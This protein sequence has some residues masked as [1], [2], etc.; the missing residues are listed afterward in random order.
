VLRS[1][2]SGITGLR[3]HQTLMDVVSN[4]IAN[5][6]TTGFKTSAVVF[7]DTLSQTMKNASAPTATSGGMNPAQVGLGVQLGAIS[8]N[9][10]QGSAQNTGKSTDLMVQGDGF[11]MVRNGGETN[12]TRSGAF[13]FDTEGTLVNS[14]GMIVQGW[15]GDLATGIVNIDNPITDIQ[16]PANTQVPP[17]ASTTVKLEGNITAG[18]TT[19]MTLGA[20]VYDAKGVAHTLQIA[21]ASNNPPAFDITVTDNLDPANPVTGAGSVGFTPAGAYDSTASTA[22]TIQLADGTTI[23][24]DITKL[25]QY[26]GPKTMAVTSADGAASGTL[27][28]FQIGQDGAVL[29]IFNNGQK[30]TI[31]KLSLASFN[32]PPG[33]EK[34]GNTLFRSTFNS[35]LAQVGVPGSG[36]RG[37][38]LGGSLEMSNVDL[39]QEF[40]NLIIAQRGF[41]ANSRVITTSDQMLQ[42]L[43]DLKR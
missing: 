16:I 2:F 36:G 37:L 5:V 32:N 24:L 35:G 22:P 3:Q 20:T 27:Q 40:T 30:L 31:A 7:E 14:E 12:Y 1:L 13:T 18:T 8:M 38:L 9:F 41:Q 34:I 15:M 17:T 23:T 43:V 28:Q 21:F 11:F 26:G 33:L 42:D 39:A 25:S 4:N 19:A 29:G 10:G 6:N